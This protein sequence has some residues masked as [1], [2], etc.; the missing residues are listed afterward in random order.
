MPELCRRYTARVIRGV[1]VQ[2]S[3]PWLVDRLATIGIAAINNVVDI[4]N[5]V[6]MECGQPL[7]AFDLAELQG[8]QIIVRQARP[9]EPLE[10][11]NHKT[12]ALDAGMCVIADAQRAVG[13]GGVMGGADTEVG[14]ATK[15]LLIEAAEFDPL[16]IRNTARQARPA[17]RFVVPFRARA[18]SG[19]RRLGQP[20]LLRIDSG[21]GRRR[22]GGGRHRLGH[23]ARGT[24]PITLRFGQLARILGIDIPQPRRPHPDGPGQSRT[25]RATPERVEV[26]PP[27]WR[28]DLTREID[29]VEEVARVHGYE[30]IPEDARVPM[31]PSH[32]TREDRVLA[33]VRHVLTAAGFDEALTLSVVEPAWSEAFS[34]WTSE[35]R[36]KPRRP[37]C[38]GPIVCAAVWCRACSAPG[39]RTKHWPIRS[40][41]CSRRPRSI[42]RSRAAICRT[43]S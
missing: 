14:P 29:L 10:A 15:D 27:S 6:L 16:S 11:I 42:W 37:F 5:Y 26:I 12:Y 22:A 25:A 34:P 33:R 40:S 31:V 8:R 18:R 23:P 17:Q 35:P 1:R 39:G 41:S 32:R 9:G 3:P 7:H 13:L 2:P 20:P 36:C 21:T 28:R 30:H 38:G 4:T 24:R 43:S 19:R